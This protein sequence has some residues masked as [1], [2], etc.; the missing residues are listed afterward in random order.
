MDSS[1]TFRREI[2]FALK[3]TARARLPSSILPSTSGSEFGDRDDN[4]RSVP[5]AGRI[6]QDN[7]FF[8]QSLRQS[9]L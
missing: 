8:R 2:R 9:I 6:W 4:V 1:A 3:P 7:H 5:R